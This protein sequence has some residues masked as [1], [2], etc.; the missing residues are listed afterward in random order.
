MSSNPHLT[1][2]S[3]KPKLHRCKN[4]LSC[5]LLFPEEASNR[6]DRDDND[7]SF[8]QSRLISQLNGLIPVNSVY[9]EY[10]ILYCACVRPNDGRA[11]A[12]IRAFPTPDSHVVT[13][14]LISS[15]HH[16]YVQ[17]KLLS[18]SY[19]IQIHPVSLLPWKPLSP[20]SIFIV[21]AYLPETWVGSAH[22]S[23]TVAAIQVDLSPGR[24][25][26]GQNT[27]SDHRES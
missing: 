20:P 13:F 12:P 21:V 14:A 3:T 22:E 10:W 9:A 1:G 4:A 25:K 27:G 17:V 24:M 18:P 26:E 11:R 23:C 19:R 15:I 16:T 7:A 2:G 8:D 6:W 5:I